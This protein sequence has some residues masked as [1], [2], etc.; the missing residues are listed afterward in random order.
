VTWR[1][2]VDA[3]DAVTTALAVQAA[4]ARL[5]SRQRAVLVLRQFE[6]LTGTA[7]AEA[8]R[9]AV[10]TVQ[11]QTRDALAALRVRVSRAEG[12]AS[13]SPAPRR[14]RTTRS[15]RCDIAGAVAQRRSG[16]RP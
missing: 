10:S 5:A 13:G 15:G 2:A 7:T 12:G 14:R 11:C 16:P 4:L 6:D 1:P 3:A 9:C 8:M